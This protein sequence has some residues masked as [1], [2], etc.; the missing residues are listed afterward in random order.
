MA[1]S[2]G[3]SPRPAD[4]SEAVAGV[5]G[6]GSAILRQRDHL[7]GRVT[8]P[9]RRHVLSSDALSTTTTCGCSG[10][11]ARKPSVLHNSP[12]RFLVA[13][14]TATLAPLAADRVTRPGAR[15]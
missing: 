15:C 8:V 14:T 1:V 12:T 2:S 6:A 4:H 7:H 10:S 9:D 13:I 11:A 3:C 5:P